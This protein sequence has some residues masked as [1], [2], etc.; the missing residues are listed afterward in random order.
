M[1]NLVDGAAGVLRSKVGGLV[2]D[3]DGYVALLELQT[4][5]W[6]LGYGSYERIGAS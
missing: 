3:S 4:Q 2:Y 1:A 5:L 6:S